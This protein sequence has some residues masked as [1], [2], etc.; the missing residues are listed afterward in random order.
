VGVQ[1]FPEHLYILYP[2]TAVLSVLAVHARFT[3]D[4]E[5]AVAERLVG[6]DGAVVSDDCWAVVKVKSPGD[7][8]EPLMLDERT[9]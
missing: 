4:D 3:C 9:V 6:T 8:A 2:V 7:E 5:T 1:P